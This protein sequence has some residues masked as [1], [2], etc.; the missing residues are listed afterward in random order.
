MLFLGNIMRDKE[1]LI[2]LI[3]ELVHV[4]CGT[5]DGSAHHMFVPAYKRA[6]SFLIQRGLMY[7]ND[8]KYFL[9]WKARRNNPNN[10][11]RSKNKMSKM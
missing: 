8:G 6:F 7:K 2:G 9:N 3:M 4:S 1:W 11:K 5:G 10:V